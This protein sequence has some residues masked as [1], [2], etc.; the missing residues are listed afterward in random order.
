M[1]LRKCWTWLVGPRVSLLAADLDVETCVAKLKDSVGP[2]FPFHS[3]SYVGWVGTDQARIRTTVFPWRNDFRSEMQL[4]LRRERS[5]TVLVCR[6][7]LPLWTKIFSL[8]W[9]GFVA[10]FGLAGAVMLLS[11][12]IPLGSPQWSVAA[13]PFG[14]LAFMFG[15]TLLGRLLSLGDDSA[16]LS[17]VR[18]KLAASPLEGGQGL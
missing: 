8:V 16:L 15:L 11:Q 1:G 12:N 13:I 9:S 6:C 5:R 7:G 2:W 17:F 10:L 3:K 4:K 14:M 18:S